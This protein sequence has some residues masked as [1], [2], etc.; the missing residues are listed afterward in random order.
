MS[1]FDFLN[2]LPNLSW[3]G[4]LSLFL[5]IF[6]RLLPIFALAPF[7]GTKV[8]P[9]PA[10]V[11]LALSVACIFLPILAPMAEVSLSLD[12]A[13]IGYLFKELLVGFI[14][15]LLISIP[16]FMVQS[17]GILIDYLRGASI[18]QAQDPTM[19]NQASPIGI[20]YNYLLIVIFFQV[21]GPFLFF[22]ALSESY[23][24]IPPTHFLNPHLF[25]AHC[26]LWKTATSLAHQIATISIQLSAPALVAILMAEMFLGIANRL[27]PQVQIAFLGMPLKSLLGLMV[28]WA[29]WFFLLKQFGN[30]ALKWVETME[31]MMRSLPDSATEKTTEAIV[32]QWL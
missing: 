23:T 15:G 5:L 28:L 11:G 6:G 2:G 18:M 4:I 27:A 21:N 7:L 20:F 10:R 3:L 19:Q 31:K 32:Q 16:F 29:G 12:T 14:L 17:S 24:L 8:A 26:P 22:N 25:D 30:H 1:Y 13:F 9:I